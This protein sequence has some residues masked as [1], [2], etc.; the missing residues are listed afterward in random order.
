M[1]NLKNLFVLLLAM[2]LAIST[3]T[4]CGGD[5]RDDGKRADAELE[6]K[7]TAVVGEMMG[8][9]MT[10]DDMAG[11]DLE[12]KA[13]GKADMTINGDP[14]SIKWTNDDSKITLDIDGTEVV[15]EIGE[16]KIS[17]VDMLDMG[18]DITFAK[19]GTD[20]ANPENYLPEEDKFMLGQWTSYK[21]TNVLGD[22]A[23]KEVDKSALV[24]EFTGDHMAKITYKGKDLG[25]HKWSLLSGV[26]GF[27]DSDLEITWNVEGDEIE[28]T[29]YGG[30]D[31]FIFSCKK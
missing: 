4:A 22:D 9:A 7:Y 27:D 6:G 28:A 8:L 24:M 2:I 11:F 23:S 25:Q 15:G 10:G 29:Y 21:V 17:F 30:D 16:D 19:E 5:K 1:K 26:G 31:Y 14:F 13:K 20:A 3:L 12:L 18:I